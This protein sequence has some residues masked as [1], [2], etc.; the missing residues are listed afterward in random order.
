MSRTNTPRPPTSDP[1]HDTSS[2]R[3]RPPRYSTHFHRFQPVS[4]T[5][6]PYLR[7]SL[8]NAALPHLHREVRGADLRKWLFSQIV[9]HRRLPIVFAKLPERARRDPVLIQAEL[10]NVRWEVREVLRMVGEMIVLYETLEDFALAVEGLQ[11]R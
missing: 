10:R 11:V 7:F 8:L 1:P 5:I 6:S 9:Q 3:N 4:R 2:P